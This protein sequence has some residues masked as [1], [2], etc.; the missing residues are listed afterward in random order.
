MFVLVIICFVSVGLFGCEKRVCGK[1]NYSDVKVLIDANLV[2]RRYGIR[3]WPP[4]EFAFFQSIRIAVSESGRTLAYYKEFPKQKWNENN[5]IDLGYS[6]NRFLRFTW[7]PNSRF[8]WIFFNDIEFEF[9]ELDGI[10]EGPLSIPNI[11]IT[12]KHEI[13]W[14]ECDERTKF[15]QFKYI[16][17][18]IKQN[19]GFYDSTGKFIRNE[20]WTVVIKMKTG[21]DIIFLKGR[22]LFSAKSFELFVKTFWKRGPR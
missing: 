2:K 22:S 19:I 4:F 6:R 15:S 10:H 7:K 1:V 17:M 18:L 5:S 3:N 14:F 16:N 21:E 8:G 20:W 9:G 11:P 13:N 12:S